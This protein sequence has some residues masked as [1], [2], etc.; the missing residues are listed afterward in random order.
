MILDINPN[1][2]PLCPNN[3]EPQHPA[4]RLHNQLINSVYEATPRDENDE[5]ITEDLDKVN[6]ALY[7]RFLRM[8]LYRNVAYDNRHRTKVEAYYFRCNV[9]GLIISATGITLP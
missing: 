2:L 6:S 7:G 3:E 8:Y 5:P 1:D 4:H 9:C